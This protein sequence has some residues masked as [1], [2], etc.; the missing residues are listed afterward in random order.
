MRVVVLGASGNVGTALLRR[1]RADPIVTSVVGV[2]RRTPAGSS[3][4]PPYDTAEWHSVDLGTTGP[5]RPVVDQLR[6][7]LAGADT[8]VNLAWQIQPSHDR[9]RLRRTHIDGMRRVLEAAL[10]ARVPHLVVASSVGAYS[11]SYTEQPRDEEWGIGGVRSSSYSVDKVAVERLLDE[12]E[13]RYPALTIA[14][15]RPALVFQ[16]AAGHAIARSFL[17]P[18]VP[19]PLLAGRVPVLPWPRGLTVQAVHADDLADAYREAIVR[20]AR[21]PFN[22]AGPGLIRAADVADVLSRGRWREV[23]HGPVRAA[24]VAAWHARLVPVGPGWFDVAVAAPVLDTGRAERQLDFR[25]R[26][27][28]VQAMRA[29]VRGIVAGSGTASPPL[30]PR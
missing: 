1:L 2:A 18:L 19:G 4:P 6:G 30:R 24:V 17:G 25:P 22:I 23:A 10:D 21:G 5:D 11:P 26:H 14:R 12:A 3:P 13:L 28:G 7:V 29:M 27:T 8:V 15:L 16:G 20:Q 9:D